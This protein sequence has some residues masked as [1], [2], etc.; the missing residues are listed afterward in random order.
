MARF[1]WADASRDERKAWMAIRAENGDT[2]GQMAALAGVTRNTI[3]GAANRAGIK[4]KTPQPI[5]LQVTHAPEAEQLRGDILAAAAQGKTPREISAEVGV[6]AQHVAFVIRQHD[7]RQHAEAM[8][9]NRERVRAA[10]YR[11]RRIAK[12]S[13]Q[14]PPPPRGSA[15]VSAAPVRKSPAVRI[16]RLF[17]PPRLPPQAA[18]TVAKRD[19]RY[20]A[21]TCQWIAG[22][23]KAQAPICGEARVVGR[24]YCLAHCCSAYQGFAERLEAING[25]L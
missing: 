1:P 4:T 22:D 16:D 13:P 11:A 17:E 7:Q 23:P 2:I 12:A 20:G 19:A 14:S 24:P 10:E 21:M 25:T 15:S 8:K 18:E 5:A 9:K 3:A 6:T